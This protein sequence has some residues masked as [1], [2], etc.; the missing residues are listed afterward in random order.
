MQEKLFDP[1]VNN[2]VSRF[3]RENNGNFLKGVIAWVDQDFSLDWFKRLEFAARIL[4]GAGF[5]HSHENKSAW[6]E[7]VV[8]IGEQRRYSLFDEEARER[9]KTTDI[10][11][12]GIVVD[13]PKDV[14]PFTIERYTR[15]ILVA[16]ILKQ[17]QIP[18]VEGIIHVQFLFPSGLQ[19]FRLLYIEDDD[20]D[21]IY[22]YCRN[23]KWWE[24]ADTSEFHCGWEATDGWAV[25]DDC[26]QD[27]HDCPRCH[28]IVHDD[29]WDPENSICNNC[30]DETE[31]EREVSDL[32]D[33]Y[34]DI[35][36]FHA[37]G[38][39][40]YSETYAIELEEGL[41]KNEQWYFNAVEDVHSYGWLKAEPEDK[42]LKYPFWNFH[43]DN[44]INGP[45]AVEVVSQP[46]TWKWFQENKSVFST[47]V[48]TFS[49]QGFESG[50]PADAGL[51]I[52]VD[53]LFFT[54]KSLYVTGNFL[55]NN[56]DFIKELSGR[57][58]RALSDWSRFIE[59]LDKQ[60]YSWQEELNWWRNYHSRYAAMNLQAIAKHGTVEFRFFNGTNDS[61]LLK[62]RIEIIHAIIHLARDWSDPR[63]LMRPSNLLR[64][65]QKHNYS[66]TA[67]EEVACALDAVQD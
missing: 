1:G 59:P 10:R 46:F 12:V 48:N 13:R 58:W 51:H 38:E 25:C 26:W 62:A 47:M 39:D 3:I 32:V 57:T 17:A 61:G 54:D 36:K 40:K 5:F 65:M 45:Y 21:E 60:E 9:F 18:H 42:Y 50:T 2:R 34:F 33:G 15:D 55:Y 41:C 7:E 27:F 35:H 29:D 8:R 24:P 11:A 28:C 4:S 56:Q 49:E 16:W 23:C 66:N 6:S 44:S 67:I 20:G 53:Y 64:Y 31:R 30:Y 19:P 63:T 43:S 52:H 37:G 22:T 14:Y